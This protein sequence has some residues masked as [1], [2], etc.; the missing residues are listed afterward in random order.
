MGCMVERYR[1]ELASEMPEID[2]FWGTG[3][4]SLLGRNIVN[5]CSAPYDTSELKTAYFV[6]DVKR[7]NGGDE[8]IFSRF[9]TTPFWRAYVKISEGC[10]NRCTYCLIPG[11]RGENIS[12][13]VSGI[14]REVNALAEKGVREV[15]LVAQDLTSYLYEN[16]DLADLLT[17]LEKDTDVTWFR[18]LYLHPSGIG[19]RLLEVISESSSVLPYL[20]IP[21]QHASDRILRRM[22]RNY[23]TRS[24][25]HLFSNIRKIIPEAAVRTTV[26]VGFPGESPEDFLILKN[27]IKKHR[28]RHMGCFVYSDED[29]CVSYRFVNKVPGELAEERR[30][31]IMEIQADISMELNSTMIGR[32]E[33]VL[34]EGISPETELLL[35]GRT[36]FQGH[37]IDG[38]TYINSGNAIA[39]DIVP[40]K[41]TS[42][43]IYDLVGEIVD[44]DRITAENPYCDNH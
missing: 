10:S 29:D 28:F 18:L 4:P 6:K 20:D 25:E 23:D 42:S 38:I 14:V 36:V 9:V 35:T 26:M 32:T 8:H 7:A 31:E 17:I 16:T 44:D 1:E 19:S 40:V 33:D 13:P 2:I 24:L 5:A 12:R 15:T 34:I 3:N 37:D 21:V 22:G 43:H 11:L 39:G 41:I 30:K 27:F